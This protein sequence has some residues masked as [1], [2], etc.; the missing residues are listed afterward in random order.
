MKSIACA[1]FVVTLGPLLTLASE[2]RAEG[3][4][5]AFAGNWS[6]TGMIEVRDG[7]RERIRC[8]GGNTESGNSLKLAL[9]CASDSYRFE[10]TGD[11]SYHGGAISG[12]WGET[13]RG[14]Y[15]SLSGRMQDALWAVRDAAILIRA[16]LSRFYDTLSDDQKKPFVIADAPPD[17]RS[18]AAALNGAQR[19]E[20][21]RM[22]GMPR[23]SDNP[24]RRIERELRLTSTQRASFDEM[25]KKA[26]AMGQFLLASCLQPI[27]STPMARLD[28][29]ADRLTSVIFAANHVGL[30]LNDAYNQLSEQ[31]QTKFKALGH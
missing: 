29:A 10:L 21:A 24:I 3:P 17:P 5:A 23:P 26:S 7:G 18:G 14:I 11:I 13:T 12:S 4:F 1:V 22:C 15:G 6:G 27:P 30:A 31:Q 20:I 25:Q 9:R 16:P 28:A 8:R 2:T 19:N